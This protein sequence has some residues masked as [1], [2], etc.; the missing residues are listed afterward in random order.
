M[1]VKEMIEKLEKYDPEMDV[2]V[3]TDSLHAE[4]AELVLEGEENGVESVVIYN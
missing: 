4:P 1:K 2:Y 3:F